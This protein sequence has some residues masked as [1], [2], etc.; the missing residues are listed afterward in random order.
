MCWGS[1]GVRLVLF[2]VPGAWWLFCLL[3]PPMV[4][5]QGL[6]G[7][8]EACGRFTVCYDA[9]SQFRSPVFLGYVYSIIVGPALKVQALWVTPDAR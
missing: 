1:G 2:G 3:P 8:K 7:K 4:E 9:G 6:R 5:R